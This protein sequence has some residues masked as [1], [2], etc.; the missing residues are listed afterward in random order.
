MPSPSNR[1]Q[2]NSTTWSEASGLG[3]ATALNM[4]DMIGVGPFITIP[5]IVG[6]MGGPQAMLGWILGAFFAICDGIVWAELGARCRLRGF[7]YYLKEI[8]GPHA[9]PPDF[10]SLHL[11]AFVQRAP[12]D[13]IRM[14]RS[15]RA[16]PLTCGHPSTIPIPHIIARTSR[17]RKLQLGSSSACD[18][19]RHRHLSCCY[20]LLYRRISRHRQMSQAPLA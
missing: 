4:I 2:G 19:P 12:F 17:T 15:R 1:A 9:G 13:C 10:V 18:L 8:Y 16:M 11:A 20:L 5:L 7:L 3:S 14:P 6:A